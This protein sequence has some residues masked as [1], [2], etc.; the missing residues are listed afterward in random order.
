MDIPARPDAVTKR[1]STS[2]LVT[3]YATYHPLACERSAR[4]F[5]V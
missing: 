2:N 3:S 1:G 4:L 5:V